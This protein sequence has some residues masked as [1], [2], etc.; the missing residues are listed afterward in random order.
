MKPVVGLDV[1]SELQCSAEEQYAFLKPNWQIHTRRCMLHLN[2]DTGDF[3]ESV[4]VLHCLT[5]YSVSVAQMHTLLLRSPY[6]IHCLARNMVYVLYFPVI[7][8][9]VYS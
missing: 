7:K 2:F 6:N 5:L 9:S 1:D 4:C 8:H 3:P